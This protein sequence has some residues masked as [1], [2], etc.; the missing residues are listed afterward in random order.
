[1]KSKI[2]SAFTAEPLRHTVRIAH[3]TSIWALPILLVAQAKPIDNKYSVGENIGMTIELI[4]VPADA[5]AYNLLIQG[6]ADIALVEEDFFLQNKLLETSGKNTVKVLCQVATIHLSGFARGFRNKFWD[7]ED[8]RVAYLE[9]SFVQ[10]RINTLQESFGCR[11]IQLRP[12]PTA[13]SAAL[14][15]LAGEVDV[16]V[17]WEPHLTAFNNML[18]NHATEIL[19]ITSSHVE[20]SPSLLGGASMVLAID[21]AT[22]SLAVL[23][24]ID[25]MNTCCTNYLSKRSGPE[26]ESESTR[27]VNL[28]PML[29][30]V[31]ESLEPGGMTESALRRALTLTLFKI[32]PLNTVSVIALW[33]K[34]KMIT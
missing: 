33:R 11:P 6:K 25:L 32:S 9:G 17:G 30:L 3:P 20:F 13:A 23:N 26:L 24:F 15:Y 8:D 10:A 31:A 1:M 7:L 22:S 34:Y 12:Y 5:Q 21:T 4:H 16:F 29:K 27:P 28:L 18:E 2:V 14:A 19:N